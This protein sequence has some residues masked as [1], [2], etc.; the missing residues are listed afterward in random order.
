MALKFQKIIMKNG[1]KAKLP[2][3]DVAEFGFCKDTDEIY[4]GSIN[5][6]IEKLTK[7][8]DNNN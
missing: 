2:K 8:F 5:N 1:N 4:I 3:L 6:N 7:V